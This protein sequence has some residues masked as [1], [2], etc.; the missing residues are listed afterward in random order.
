MNAPKI[1]TGP[2]NK[3]VPTRDDFLAMARE[4]A[5]K[6]R[7][8]S[9]RCEE[10]RRLPEETIA[11]YK[12][13]GLTRVSQPLRYGGYE[14]TWDV[15]CE[16]S[17]VLAA[18]CGSQAW[19]QRIMADHAL[20][21]ATFED[22]A[23][24]DVWGKDVNTLVSASFDP[25]GRATRVEGGYLFSG[26][27]GFSSG[28]DYAGWMI[29]GGHI[30]DGDRKDG[31]HFFLVPR[32]DVTIIDDWKTMG[33]SG[34]GSKSFVVDNKFIPAH[35]FLNGKLSREGRGPGTRFNTAPVY[36]TP[37][38]GGITATG[39]AALAVGMG[40]GVLQE[41]LAFTGPRKSRGVA[42]GDL[43]TT[44]I[45]AAEASAEL[46]AAELLFMTALRDAMRKLESGG[47]ITA[48]E[49]AA[50]KR[51][52]AFAAKLSLAAGTRLFNQ[53]GGRALFT[54]GHLQRQYR[55]LL[56]AASHHAV[57]WEEAGVEYGSELLKR[58]LP[59][60]GLAL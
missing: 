3:A 9:A 58:F 47:E 31:P 41:W 21:V 24:H 44:H 48:E 6:L 10:M 38:G 43:A 60:N 36:R 50:S 27:H 45:I 26:R 16:V 1:E 11:D 20:L 13:T 2:P 52:V 5:P 33:L 57:V 34:T 14:M 18:A 54:D 17:Q 22:E 23:Q 32:R 35:R 30:L 25:V 39:F 49:K 29:C 12:H 8:R 53:A 42:I 19:I 7:D 28:I 51:N 15:L 59:S 37:R 46:D 56:G 55:N 40:R 4:L